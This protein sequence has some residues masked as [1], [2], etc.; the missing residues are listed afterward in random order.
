[1]NV[2]TAITLA[3]IFLTPVLIYLMYL[4][5]VKFLAAAFFAVLAVS[6]WLDGYLAR[7]YKEET[8]VGKFLDPLADKILVLSVLIVL[9]V[10]LKVEVFSVLILTAREFAI[11]GIRTIA[12]GKGKIIA[13]SQ[14]AKLKTAVQMTAIFFLLADWPFGLVLY[15]ISF[16][17]ALISLAEYLWHNKRMLAGKHG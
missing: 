5:K 4:P 1:M 8:I 7:K 14:S 11:M 9:A 6:D 15:Y 16:V 13:A 12:A 17:I 3:R 2:A 10:Q